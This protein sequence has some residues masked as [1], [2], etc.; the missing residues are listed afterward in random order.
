MVQW[1]PGADLNHR[2]ADFQ[3][4][5]LP[6]EL[7]GHFVNRFLSTTHK[8]LKEERLIK[9]INRPVQFPSTGFSVHLI[10]QR[11][12]RFLVFICWYSIVSHEPFS[13]VIIGTVFRAKWVKFIAL[14]FSTDGATLFLFFWR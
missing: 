6:T 13:E 10:R 14:R 9:E 3:S 1:C 4:A 7:P 12:I 8:L 2:H 11:V 5:A